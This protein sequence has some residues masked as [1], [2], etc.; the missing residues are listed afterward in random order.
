M[1]DAAP[2]VELRA[3]VRLQFR[4]D[5]PLDHATALVPYLHA[6]GIS[7]IYASPL[8]KSRSGSTHGYDIVDHSR[9]DPELGGEA[10][11]RRLVAALR[12]RGMGLILDIVPNHMGVGGAD[13]AWW[14]DVL[15]WGRASPYAAFFDID[16]DPPDPTLRGRLLAPFLGAPY[17]E[18][19]AAG[20]LV[21]RFDAD[22]GRFF[23]AA[24][25]THR[26][27][28]APRDY[29]AILRAAGGALDDL[30]GLFTGGRDAARQ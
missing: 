8:L 21:L 29:R 17:G 16:W 26:F 10:A 13:N 22:D 1:T 12:A 3:T 20:D 27:P 7:H 14:L 4:R 9:I 25:D 28:I 15:E 6:L 24:Y 11:L 23:V 18:V 5:F 2:A 19:L 30:A